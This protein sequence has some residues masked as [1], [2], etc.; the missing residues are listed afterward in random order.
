LCW[1]V[2]LTESKLDH[3]MLENGK[4]DEPSQRGEA[5]QT[6]RLSHQKIHCLNDVLLGVVMLGKGQIL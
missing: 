6:R 5:S 1:K 2:Y 4:K 3:T